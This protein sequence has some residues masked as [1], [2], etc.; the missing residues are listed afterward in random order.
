MQKLGIAVIGGGSISKVHIEAIKY[1]GLAELICIVENDRE[2]SEELVREYDVEV[3]TDY[4][5]ILDRDDIDVVHI[6]TPH[7]N[8]Y[9]I[10]LAF[11]KHK[12]NLLIEKP[13]TLSIKEAE[14]LVKEAEKNK[15]SAAIVYQNRLNK[16]SIYLKNILEE[17]KYGKILGIKGILAWNRNPDYY[18]SSSWKGTLDKEGG[19]VLI[20]QA[21][22]TLDLIIWLGGEIKTLRGS[23][24]KN[25]ITNE[26]EVEDT[27]EAYMIFENGARGVFYATNNYSYDSSI[28]L[29]VHCESGVLNIKNNKLRLFLDDEETVLE[30]DFIRDN[31]NKKCY[32]NSHELLIKNFY[33]SIRNKTKDYIDIKEGIKALKVIQKIYKKE[34]KSW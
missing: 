15:V 34:E 11:I 20:N 1:S 27:A 25:R 30:E 24:R 10:S 2:K 6:T 23:F 5:K 32:G 18:L 29:E 13:L 7:Y 4:R 9:E 17:G 21:I 22:H 14:H 12:K 3:I 16:T 28:E 8:H 33:K 19:G 26:I 31:V